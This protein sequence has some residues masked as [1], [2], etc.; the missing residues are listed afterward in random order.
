MTYTDILLWAKRGISAEIDR[1]NTALQASQRLDAQSSQVLREM[2][3]QN[4]NKLKDELNQ[5]EEL[6]KDPSGCGR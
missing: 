2:I 4:M 1:Q 3:E 5:V 6:L